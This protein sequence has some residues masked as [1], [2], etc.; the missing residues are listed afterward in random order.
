MPI[1]R[2]QIAS[3]VSYLDGVG[4]MS[5]F[6]SSSLK[7]MGLEEIH[8]YIHDI[9]VS[10]VL[11]CDSTFG[12]LIKSSICRQGRVIKCTVSVKLIQYS[13]IFID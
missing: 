8:D 5:T 4:V 3:N 7:V 1:S 10:F 11:F 13:F 2:E 6:G 12:K 9:N